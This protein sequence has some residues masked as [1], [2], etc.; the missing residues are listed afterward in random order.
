MALCGQAP[1][2]EPAHGMDL[3]EATRRAVKPCGQ[4]AEVAGGAEVRM[5]NI[6]AFQFDKADETP[7]KPRVRS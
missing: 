4:V 3:P 1:P 7:K 2:I 5:H 6:D